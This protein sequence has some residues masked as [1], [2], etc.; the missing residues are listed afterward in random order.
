MRKFHCIQCQFDFEANPRFSSSNSKKR[1]LTEP[2]IC[3]KC[4]NLLPVKE[5][6]I[7]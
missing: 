2:V 5:S 6:E 3:P 7:K 1:N 4:Q